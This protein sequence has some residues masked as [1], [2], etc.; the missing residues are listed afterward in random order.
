MRRGGY[1]LSIVKSNEGNA[2]S[3]Q[4]Y[5]FDYPQPVAG[6]GHFIQHLPE[7]TVAPIPS[8]AG[9][10]LH[11]A[12]D[13]NDPDTFADKLW[14]NLN[15][16]NKVSLF[17][18][19]IELE[20]GAYE[21]VILNKYTAVE[22]LI[23]NELQLKYGCN[24]NQK[25]ARIFMADGSDLPV[26]DAERPPG[27]HQLSGRVQLLAAGARAEEGHWA[28]PP[29]PASS[30][31]SPAGAAIGLPLIETL[32]RHVLHRARRPELSPLACAYAR[33]RGADR[34]SCFGDW[35]A[36]SDVC[37]VATAKLISARGVRRHHRP[38]LRLTEALE[39]LKSKKKGNYNIVQI[40]A[41]YEPEA[42]GAHAPSSA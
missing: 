22:V 36:L 18:R 5:T 3:V 29:P 42:A 21:D 1:K 4:R 20:T 34:M 14:N 37:D 8:F 26:A 24:P 2:A 6:E 41:A 16:D 32:Q 35:I 33:A 11:V 25:P 31:S 12:I 9:E 40:D 7:A 19:S 39:M 23:M 28:S 30:T 17:V 10:P 38:R 15:E 27:L 13:E